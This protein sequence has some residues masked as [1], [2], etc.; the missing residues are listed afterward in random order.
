MNEEEEGLKC[1]SILCVS[2]YIYIREAVVGTSKYE[3][4]GQGHAWHHVIQLRLGMNFALNVCWKARNATWLGTSSPRG[5]CP[6]H[7]RS[8]TV[9]DS[10]TSYLGS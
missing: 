2:L 10:A 3:L 8:Q 1:M 6:R 9:S 4:Q 7:S 5:F